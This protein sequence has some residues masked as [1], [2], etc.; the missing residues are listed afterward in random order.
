LFAATGGQ[1]LYAYY[2]ITIR[3]NNKGPGIAE[4]LILVCKSRLWRQQGGDPVE[5]PVEAGAHELAAA[6][7]RLKYRRRQ[8]VL[9][10]GCGPSF[11]T[12]NDIRHW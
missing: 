1:Q 7:I 8:S 5:R 11:E 9:N 3:R 2:A 4:A 6:T 10:R 12:R